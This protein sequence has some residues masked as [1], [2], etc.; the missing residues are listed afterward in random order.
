MKGR[1]KDRGGENGA[2]AG[3][4]WV[5][6][7]RDREQRLAPAAAEVLYEGGALVRRLGAALAAYSGPVPSE[8]DTRWLEGWGVSVVRSLG[9]EL[10]LVKQRSAFEEKDHASPRSIHSS[11]AVHV[12]ANQPSLVPGGFGPLGE[13]GQRL[14]EGPVGLGG[15]VSLAA[16]RDEQ[17]P[18]QRKSRCVHP[19]PNARVLRDDPAT[20]NGAS[21]VDPPQ[22]IA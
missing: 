2:S 19:A 9:R 1:G 8:A 15:R 3:E 4:V 10:P 20:V 11:G 5:W 7:P 16:R 14:W 13:L 12:D 17:Q 21:L 22:P 18:D 6:L